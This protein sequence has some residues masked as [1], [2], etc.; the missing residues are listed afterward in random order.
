MLKRLIIDDLI[1]WK[2]NQEKKVLIVKGA[3]QVGKTFIINHFGNN[4]YDNYIMINFEETPSAKDIFSG[5][6]DANTIYNK[7]SLLF[8]NKPINKNTLIFLDEIQSCPNARVALKFLAIDD[9][10]DIIASGS[11]LGI[12]YIEVSS[13]PVGYTLELQM[14]SLNFIEY[15]FAYGYDEKMLNNLYD[16]YV[17][18]NKIDAFIHK[19]MMEVFKEY[20][21]VGG[22]PSAVYSY[23]KNKSFHDVRIIQKNIISNYLDDI[24][25]YAKGNEKTKARECF[26]SIPKNLSKDYKKFQYSV[27]K[28]K[29]RAKDYEGSL[30]WLIDA[31]LISCCYNVTQLELPLEGNAIN[32]EFKVYLNDTGLLL[33]MFDDESGLDILNDNL[34][35]YKGA[36]YENIIAE[37]LTK[38]NKKLYY[39]RKKSGL[40]LDFLL[41]EK[42]SSQ[43]SVIEVKSSENTKAKSFD[44]SLKTTENLKGIKLSKRNISIHNNYI[45]Y[46]LY[47]SM[48]IK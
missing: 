40:E 17:N 32:E 20:I 38:S 41:R 9:R 37:I 39:F 34:G 36:I 1:K 24:S 6:L 30:R 29:G 13:F 26:L 12:N 28:K 25:K 11:L 18:K 5:D 42:E 33:S 16:S 46:P 3:R 14:Y 15:L 8:P 19:K 23:I 35:I 21:I 22:M 4:Y 43:L 10:T 44:L 47:L 7:I 45:E 31:G 48:F 2:D 27:V